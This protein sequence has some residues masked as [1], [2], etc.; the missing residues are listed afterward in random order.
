M[1]GNV[2]LKPFEQNFDFLDKLYDETAALQQAKDEARRVRA[3]EKRNEQV[4]QLFRQQTK[5]NRSKVSPISLSK[6][7]AIQ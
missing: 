6:T 5:A 7:L 1:R 4:R 3:V 2:Q